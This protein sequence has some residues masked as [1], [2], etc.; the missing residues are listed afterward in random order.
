MFLY[1]VRRLLMMVPTLFGITIISF[2]IINLAPGSPVEQ[3]LQAL[4]FGGGAGTPG[5]ASTNVRDTAVT[6]EVVEALKKQYG[7]DKPL[8]VRYQIWLGN[9][10]R[11]NFGESF[12]YEEPVTGVIISKFP[13]SLQFGIISFFLS[14]LVCIPLGIAMGV[15]D[16]SVFDRTAGVVLFVLYS[17]PPLMLGI[18]LIVFFGGGS[19][20]DWFPIGGLY[21]DDYAYYNL[22][23]KII[24]RAQH[25]VLPLICYMI[26]SFTVLTMLMKNSL[27]DVI[28]LDYIRTARAKGLSERVV[29]FKHALRNALIPIATGIGGFLGLFFSGSIII[30][31]LFQLD[32][33]GLLGYN[34]VLARDY[35]VIMGLIFIQ[36]LLML[37]GRLLSDLAYVLIDPRIDFS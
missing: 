12:K 35:N 36:S 22:W 33:M 2:I 16:E 14:Y 13:V 26:G 5:A 30:E 31:Q 6:E 23:G 32:G 37:V 1:I 7:F 10:L 29:Y 25:F 24:D 17:V 8:L 11:L 4:R 28:R 3:K 20:W 19:Y 27:L 15:R 34:S 9:L 18:L 21:S